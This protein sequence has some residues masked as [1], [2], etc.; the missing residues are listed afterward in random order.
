MSETLIIV[1][2]GIGVFAIVLVMGVVLVVLARLRRVLKER[3]EALDN[4]L[5]T[6]QAGQADD[7]P[8]EP[9]SK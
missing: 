1:V 3:F 5:G 6:L 9:Q 4:V 2:L 7:K 8:G